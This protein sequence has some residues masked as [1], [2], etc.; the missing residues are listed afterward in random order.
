MCLLKN[1]GPGSEKAGDDIPSPVIGADGDG[2]SSPGLTSPSSGKMVFVTVHSLFGEHKISG[3]VHDS[4][5][6]GIH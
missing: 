6:P 4:E 1:N 5:S 3:I 2:D